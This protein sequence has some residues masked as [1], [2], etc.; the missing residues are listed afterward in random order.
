MLCAHHILSSSTIKHI[1]EVLTVACKQ[2]SKHFLWNDV[3][4]KSLVKRLT[5][6]HASGLPGS[7]KTLSSRAASLVVTATAHLRRMF[8]I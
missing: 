5:T 3:A 6:E 2:L 7:T 4:C 1:A 8:A